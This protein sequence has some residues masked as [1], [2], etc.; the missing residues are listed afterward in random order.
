MFFCYS[1]V[2]PACLYP[3][4]EIRAS[5]G[6]YSRRKFGGKKLLR[7][8]NQQKRGI[9]SRHFSNNPPVE[10]KNKSNKKQ[11]YRTFSKVCP[12]SFWNK[13]RP[14]MTGELG[15]EVGQLCMLVYCVSVW[16]TQAV[17]V[18][19]HICNFFMKKRKLR[20]WIVLKLLSSQNWY[21]LS[22]MCLLY[23]MHIFGYFS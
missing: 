11:I 8:K 18:F 7:H 20:Y 19:C 4:F 13:F 15:N 2:T 1:S 10:K 6:K 16:S 12:L 23:S 22:C 17:Y 14:L 3:S 5:L 21:E 9:T